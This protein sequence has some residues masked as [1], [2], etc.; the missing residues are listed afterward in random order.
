MA[1]VMKWCIDQKVEIREKL[2]SLELIYTYLNAVQELEHGTFANGAVDVRLMLQ[3]LDSIFEFLSY[4]CFDDANINSES[5]LEYLIF[6]TGQL[7]QLCMQN[8]FE[9]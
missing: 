2:V 4:D 8:N 7:N 3:Y 5:S 6:I 9:I 1:T